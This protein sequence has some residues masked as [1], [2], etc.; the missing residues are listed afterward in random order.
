MPHPLSL[1]D[2]WKSTVSSEAG[3]FDPQDS[4]HLPAPAQR[5]LTHAIAPGT[6]LASAVRLSMHGEIKLKQWYPFRAEQ[7]IHGQRGMIWQARVWMNG[8]PIWG[9]DRLIDGAGAM[10]WKLLGLFPIVTASG[11]EIARSATGRAGGEAVWLPSILCS[12][13]VSWTSTDTAYVT[14]HVMRLNEP[15]DLKLGINANGKLQD[16]QFQRWGNPTGEFDYA[17]FGGIVEAEGIFDGYTIPTQMRMGWY[18]GSERFEPEGEF[19]RVTI[20]KAQYR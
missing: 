18:F 13:A 2:L 10:Q 16:I 20:D 14:A 11:P 7:V 5:Y 17:S 8:L 1:N 12:Q 15:I 3:Q 4:S 6:R 9:S 19:F